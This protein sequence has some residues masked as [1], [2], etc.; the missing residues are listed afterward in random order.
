MIHLFNTLLL[1]QAEM[2]NY[3][4]PYYRNLRSESCTPGKSETYEIQLLN[5]A[6]KE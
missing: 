2:T 1:T 6:E 4:I 5:R 3:D